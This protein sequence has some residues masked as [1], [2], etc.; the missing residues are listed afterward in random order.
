M[1]RFGY[2]QVLRSAAFQDSMKAW[3]RKP[4]TDKTWILFKQFMIDEYD[5]YLEDMVAG[6][7]NPYQASLLYTDETLTTLTGI[8]E[9]LTTDRAKLTEMGVANL[10]IKTENAA[11]KETVQ[12]L[13]EKINSLFQKDGA[14]E[15]RVARCEGKKTSTR[16]SP[17]ATSPESEILFHLRTTTL[18]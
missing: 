13:T 8:A 6:D 12:K 1:V 9:N 15:T 7:A 18:V 11:L 5:D 10:T 3:R 17:A 2:E 16:S 14:L 4:S